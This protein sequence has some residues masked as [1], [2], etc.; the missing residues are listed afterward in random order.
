MPH[1]IRPDLFAI[2]VE[3]SKEPGC[4]ALFSGTSS[5]LKVDTWE[6]V[7][8][9]TQHAEQKSNPSGYRFYPELSGWA[10]KLIVSEYEWE[11]VVKK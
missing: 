6:R 10:L 3:S 1:V 11:K 4:F 5:S 2:R 8:Y 7:L 9:L